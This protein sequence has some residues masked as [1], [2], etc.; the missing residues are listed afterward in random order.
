[1]AEKVTIADGRPARPG[2]SRQTVSNVLNSPHIVRE[3]TRRASRGVQALGYRVNQAARQMRTGRSRLSPPASNRPGTTASTA[4]SSTVSCT[5]SPSPPTPPAT[6]SCSTP[7]PTTTSRARHLRRPARR[8]RAGRFVLTGTDYG[9]PRTAWLCDRG[10]PVRDFRPAVGRPRATP[11]GRRRR[12]RRHRPWPPATARRRPPADRPSRLARR[13]PASATTGAPAGVRTLAAGR[14]SDP[15]GCTGRVRG[16][17]RQGRAADARAA[18][19]PADPP[20]GAGLRE[21]LA[22][23]RRAPGRPGRTRPP[24][25]GSTTRRSP[26]RSG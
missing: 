17:H 21:R 15:A 6:G 7:R 23:A 1:M 26:R 9:D 10:V 22:G 20:T 13:A 18:R 19:R 11:L 16:R 5:A 12:R 25:S 8:V 2:V 24:S 3:E 14:P 4:S